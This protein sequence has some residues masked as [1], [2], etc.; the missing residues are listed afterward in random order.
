M[1]F[2]EKTTMRAHRRGL[3]AAS[4]LAL[5]TGALAPAPSWAQ[6]NGAGI[7]S[8]LRQELIDP[9]SAKFGKLT[10]VGK[11]KACLTVN[12]K[13]RMG[14]YTGNQQ[15]YMYTEKGKW[16]VALV[17]PDSVEDCVAYQRLAPSK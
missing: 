15:A 2:E 8:A 4:C 1:T 3:A 6:A 16:R 7:R 10:M 17:A 5:A 9:D 12:S 14:G 11:D 13:N